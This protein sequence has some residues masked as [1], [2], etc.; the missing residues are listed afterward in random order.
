[1]REN[2]ALWLFVFYIFVWWIVCISTENDPPEA[3]M[4]ELKNN[5][6]TSI[7]YYSLYK[8]SNDVFFT[9]LTRYVH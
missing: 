5:K 2:Y 3:Y 4:D 9:K 8:V 7:P 6:W 1:M